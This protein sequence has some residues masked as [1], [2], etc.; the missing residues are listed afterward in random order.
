M[1]SPLIQIQNLA[2]ALIRFEKT[3]LTFSNN[4]LNLSME[5]N[6]AHL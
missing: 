5:H 1:Y 4:F 6:G 2:Y 3:F